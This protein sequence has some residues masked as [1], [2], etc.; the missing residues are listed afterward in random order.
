MIRLLLKVLNDI[1]WSWHDIVSILNPSLRF[2]V[3]FDRCWVYWFV[4]ADSYSSMKLHDDHYWSCLLHVDLIAKFCAW[5]LSQIISFSLIVVM[6]LF[7]NNYS[8]FVFLHDII[9]VWTL[10][11]LNAWASN[12]IVNMMIV[13]DSHGMQFTYSWDCSWYGIICCSRVFVCF[14]VIMREKETSCHF[15]NCSMIAVRL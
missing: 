8:N 4:I 15:M 13:F 11:C 7:K 10:D 14:V 2:I 1:V 5:P 9:Y 6:L 3:Y 12:C